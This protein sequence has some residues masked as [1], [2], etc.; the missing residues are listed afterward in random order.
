[1]PLSLHVRETSF[2]FPFHEI[3][4]L[5][6]P[7]NEDS[8]YGKIERK[9]NHNGA[10]IVN[11]DTARPLTITGLH[12]KDCNFQGDH[13][14]RGAEGRREHVKHAPA[15][16]SIKQEGSEG[17]YRNGGKKNTFIVEEACELPVTTTRPEKDRA[18]SVS[19]L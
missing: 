14:N 8:C 12:R 10:G 6:H 3:F 16:I 13:T 11:T 7:G 4:V 15:K 9:K 1:M 2:P 18:G 17:D 19:A 5:S